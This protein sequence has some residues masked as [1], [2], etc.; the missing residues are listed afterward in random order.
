MAF[1]M[2]QMQAQAATEFMMAAHRF[3]STAMNHSEADRTTK[4]E[5]AAILDAMPIVIGQRAPKAAV[6][7]IRG[8]AND[9]HQL[10]L[11]MELEEGRTDG[12]LV[13]R[14]VRAAQRNVEEAKSVLNA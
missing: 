7:D 6:S 9:I 11:D 14:F 3:L 12:F 1:T 10:V 13:D 2:A 8:T 5:I 4:R